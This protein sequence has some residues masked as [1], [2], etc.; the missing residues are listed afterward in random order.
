[1]IV[2]VKLGVV[3]FEV[4]GKI[5]MRFYTALRNVS[6]LNSANGQSETNKIV[7]I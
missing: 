6:A 7:F 3:R 2:H 4:E 5:K 1:M